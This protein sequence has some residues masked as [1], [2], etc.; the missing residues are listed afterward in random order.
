MRKHITIAEAAELLPCS[1]SMARKLHRLGVI[2]GHRVGSRLYFDRAAV[3][4]YKE[5]TANTPAPT[6]PPPP[7]KSPRRSKRPA[8]GAVK[9]VRDVIAEILN[10]SARRAGP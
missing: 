6:A 2:R 5:R 4:E 3:E 10:P 1:E 7:T 9:D 8:P